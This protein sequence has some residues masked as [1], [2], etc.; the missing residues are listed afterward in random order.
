MKTLRESLLGDMENNLENGGKLIQDAYDGFEELKKEL[1]FKKNYVT[2]FM[3]STKTP[4]YKVGGIFDNEGLWAYL[5][6]DA[7]YLEMSIFKNEESFKD[8]YLGIYLGKRKNGTTFASVNES[9][10][11]YIYLNSS[12]FKSF[13]DVLSKFIKP[14]VKDIDAFK[15]SLEKIKYYNEKL[16]SDVKYIIK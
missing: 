12:V 2:T 13:N 6:H 9:Y 14:M 5:G 8:W 7:N 10:D 15:T 11:Y 4:S 3:H 1:S 16:I